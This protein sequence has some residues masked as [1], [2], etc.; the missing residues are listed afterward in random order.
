MGHRIPCL[1]T[2]WNASSKRRASST[3]RPT[4]VLLSVT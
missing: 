3:E 2:A 4:V 1:A